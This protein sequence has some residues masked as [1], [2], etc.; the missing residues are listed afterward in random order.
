VGD[1]VADQ[2]D[3]PP[4]SEELVGGCCFCCGKNPNQKDRGAASRKDPELGVKKR[5]HVHGLSLPAK[6]RHST[7]AESVLLEGLS[8][9]QHGHQSVG[10]LVPGSVCIK[11]QPL[12]EGNPH[13]AWHLSKE[14]DSLPLRNVAKS[15]GSILAKLPC[16]KCLL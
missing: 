9:M 7:A 5:N 1:A 8:V 16:E 3:Y 10:F 14:I 6:C 2:G 12:Q 4:V 11:N 13:V 15:H